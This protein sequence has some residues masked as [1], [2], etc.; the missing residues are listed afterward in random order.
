MAFDY[1][2]NSIIGVFLALKG[3]EQKKI[4]RFSKDTF[5]NPFLKMES[6]K[7]QSSDASLNH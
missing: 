4:G 6:A 5:A 7:Q 3:V 2:I 1:T